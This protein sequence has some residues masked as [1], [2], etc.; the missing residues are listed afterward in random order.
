[1]HREPDVGFDPGSPGSRP[2]LKAGAKL[3]SHPGIPQESIL[4]GPAQASLAAFPSCAW[5]PF[6]WH[7]QQPG[8][9]KGEGEATFHFAFLKSECRF[10]FKILFIGIPGWLSSLAPAFAQ[11]LILETRDHTY[12]TSGSLN[13]ACFSLCLC[14]CLSVSHK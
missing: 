6:L 2:G 8:Y 13:G 5:E 11:G 7:F 3:L 12:P 4:H 10:H 1:M 14:L 9:Q